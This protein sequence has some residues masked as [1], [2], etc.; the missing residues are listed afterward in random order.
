[1]DTAP[2]FDHWVAIRSP[3]LFSDPPELVIESPELFFDPPKLGRESQE[4]SI[5]S[6]EPFRRAR[7]LLG[8]PI[9]VSGES[10]KSSVNLPK[11][12]SDPMGLDLDSPV[13]FSEAP[14]SFGGSRTSFGDAIA[15]F[16]RCS[17]SLDGSR[18]PS[19]EA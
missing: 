3:E 1:M 17:K 10:L 14:A 13:S 9:E 8:G 6:R 5:G 19:E 2:G 16:G 18:A 12:F 4:P 7:E 11:R 15:S